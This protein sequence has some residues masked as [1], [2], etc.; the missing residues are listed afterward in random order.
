[1]HCFT[2]N[3]KFSFFYRP[4]YVSS[5]SKLLAILPMAMLSMNA[6][7]ANQADS[8]VTFTD[9][10]AEKLAGYSRGFG[11][12]FE[13]LAGSAWLDYDADNDLD[14]FLTN[15]NSVPD[16]NITNEAALFRN[17]GD[18]TFSNVATA[19]G[20]ADTLGSGSVAAGDLDN[21][22][23]TD[24]F[25]TGT[26]SLVGP[27]QSPLRIYWNNGDGTFSLGTFDPGPETAGT[28]ALG[29]INND[30]LLDIFVTA[31]GRLPMT[32]A[33][34]QHR[35]ALFLNNGNRTFD[36]ISASAGVDDFEDGACAATFTDSD[37]DG[38]I[39]ILVANCNDFDESLPG[40]I[41]PT[42]F[43]LYRNNG[44]NTFTDIAQDVGLG[45]IGSDPAC[46]VTGLGF[47]MGLAVADHDLDGDLDFF[48]TSF[49]SFG[50][51]C[52]NHGLYENDGYGNYVNVADE[53]GI[54]ALEF[55]WGASFADFD[56]DGDSDLYFAGSFAF[57]GVIGTGIGNPGY[58]LFNQGDG[59]YVIADQETSGGDFSDLYTSGVAVADFDNDGF[60]DINVVTSPG[61]IM[62][63]T[64]VPGGQPVLL[65]NSG[66]KNNALTLKLVGTNSN[67]DGIGALIRV[68]A[69]PHPNARSPHSSVQTLETR[70]GS[71]FASSETPWPT[72][73]LGRYKFA[74]VTVTWPSGL[75]EKFEAKAG[76]ETLVEGEGR[77]VI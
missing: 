18:G 29:D 41:V 55:G 36:D 5:R 71:S 9:V 60:V 61:I 74:S 31:S 58:L 38:R 67:R 12:G 23:H 32:A 2:Q 30:S 49:G 16:L 52:F 63:G 53:L 43:S 64:S 77:R 57:P 10:G 11:N 22:G 45:A 8:G 37:R 21:D 27:E 72:F 51:G 1:M 42:P 73:G 4:S 28:A 17:N 34:E 46:G 35:N 44:D 62:D 20:V 24:L 14:L 15:A 6:A 76:F 40:L 68:K 50:G 75:I 25:I 66:N 48:S 47:W 3:Q 54:G 26:S 13:G 69:K 39:D 70:A 7:C 59:S 33:G 65:H 19:A 56:A